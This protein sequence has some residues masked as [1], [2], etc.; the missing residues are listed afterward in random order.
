MKTLFLID[1]TIIQ[2]MLRFY[3]TVKRAFS[4]VTTNVNTND[5]L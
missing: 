5:Q 1:S 2:K 3:K 4:L